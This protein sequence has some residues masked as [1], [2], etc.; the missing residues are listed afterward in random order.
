MNRVTGRVVVKESGAGVADLVSTMGYVE[1]PVPVQALV[2]VLAI[3]TR[4]P[5]GSIVAA[6]DLTPLAKAY[7]QGDVETLERRVDQVLGRGAFRAW[8]QAMQ[9]ALELRGDRDV[10]G[11]EYRHIAERFADA[12]RIARKYQ[13]G[14]PSG[15]P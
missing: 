3:Q 7:F 11:R 4:T 2:D 10:Q 8:D 1:A 13:R 12:L 5:N 9:G 6:P 14:L 15:A